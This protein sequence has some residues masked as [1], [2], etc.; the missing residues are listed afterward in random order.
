MGVENAD[1]DTHATL[2]TV[3][4]GFNPTNSTKTTLTTM[5]RLLRSGHPQIANVAMIFGEYSI[6]ADTI[7]P[8][9]ERSFE[10]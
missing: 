4:E 7:I 5:K 2:S 1:T 6:A 3:A 10:R 9:S 8:A